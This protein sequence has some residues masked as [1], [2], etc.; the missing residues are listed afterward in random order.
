V[1][2]DDR[3]GGG[4]DGSW[5][6][7]VSLANDRMTSSPYQR[8][9]GFQPTALTASVVATG[10]VAVI[11]VTGSVNGGWISNPPSAAAQNLS[12]TENLYVDMV[13]APGA[14]D[15]TGNGTTQILVPGQSFTIPP[16][17]LGHY[18][19]VNAATSGHRFSGEVW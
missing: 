6:G 8:T 1:R 5:S 9:Y 17:A 4:W 12:E 3:W 7:P 18:V 16:L 19:Y 13:S 11:A 10:G 14:T 15:A 2:G